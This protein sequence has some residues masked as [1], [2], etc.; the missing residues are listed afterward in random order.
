M[1]PDELA[2]L[3]ACAEQA[4]WKWPTDA[5]FQGCCMGCAQTLPICICISGTPMPARTWDD[6]RAEKAEWERRRRERTV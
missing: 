5:L 3:R 6:M 1:T 2:R 4:R